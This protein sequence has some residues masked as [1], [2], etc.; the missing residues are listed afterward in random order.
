MHCL[1]SLACA[2][3]ILMAIYN[4]QII[5]MPTQE[6]NVKPL[7]LFLLVVSNSGSSEFQITR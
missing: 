5:K 2:M 3:A 1:D 6:E 4:L 7:G